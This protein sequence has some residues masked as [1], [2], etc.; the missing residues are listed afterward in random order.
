MNS[1]VD[2]RPN[3]IVDLVDALPAPAE[4]LSFGAGGRGGGSGAQKRR[5]RAPRSAPARRRGLGGADGRRCAGGAHARTG[6][7]CHRP[8]GGGDLEADGRHAARAPSVQR[9]HRGDVGSGRR[10]RSERSFRVDLR[11]HG[12]ASR[13]P[14]HG[15]ARRSGRRVVVLR[16]QD[17]DPVEPPDE[18]L[19]DGARAAHA[20]IERSTF[21]ARASRSTSPR[22]T[23]SGRIPPVS[24]GESPTRSD[25][26]GGT[27]STASTATTS[28]CEVPRID[29]ELW[30][31]AGESPLP[32]K[33]VVVAKTARGAPTF[34]AE[35]RSWSFETALATDA[36]RF[37]APSGAAR[38]PL[39][40]MLE[41]LPRPQIR[42]R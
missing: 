33:Y 3:H 40:E 5:W 32:R 12:R 20:R 10:G 37:E 34:S 29:R 16:R 30:I 1:A 41:T 26:P 21:S 2:R 36:F 18:L 25:T 7:P 38:I 39:L 23:C 9:R 11:A 4:R 15:P 24:S 35:F 17:L 19:R 28:C 27:R 8:P 13:P 42:E 6:R 14:A 31:E 22:R